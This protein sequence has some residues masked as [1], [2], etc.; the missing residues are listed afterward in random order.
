MFIVQ[1]MK[2]SNVRGNG[3]EVWQIMAVL[4]FKISYLY[5]VTKTEWNSK[6][7]NCKL[8][9]PGTQ[10]QHLFSKKPKNNKKKGRS[11]INIPQ[12]LPI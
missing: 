6:F 10:N 12:R 1:D 9:G 7:G 8:E 4:K 3:N 5:P 2:E 11:I